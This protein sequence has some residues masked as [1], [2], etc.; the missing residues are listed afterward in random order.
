VTPGVSSSKTAA[1]LF[2][3]NLLGVFHWDPTMPGPEGSGGYL[4]CTNQT[5]VPGWGY[6]VKMSA[7]Y[8]ADMT[9]TA[10]ASPKTMA[11]NKGW[12]QIGNPFEVDIAV[13]KVSITKNFV[14]KSLAEAYAAGW[15]SPLFS[16]DG[17]AY[18]ILD[19]TSGV[20]HKGQGF[21]VRVLV[22]GCSITY[23]R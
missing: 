17:S 5:L 10:V 21:W 13:S 18:Q 20:L 3:P 7:A 14:T 8:V 6:W 16:Y 22:D 4:V 9:G 12:E 19:L 15:I 2:G 23:T 11:L 1:E